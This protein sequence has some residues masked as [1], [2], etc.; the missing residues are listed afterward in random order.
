MFHKYFKL[1]IATP[2]FVWAGGEFYKG[3]IMNG[4]SIVFLASVFIFLYFKNEI[5]LV[6]FFKIRKQNMDGAKKWLAK[7]KSPEK[8]LI[9][10]QQAYYYFLHGLVASQTNIR[11]C[12]KFFRK[13]LAMGLKMKHNIA[14]AKLNLAGVALHKRRKR[15]ATL[16]ISEAKKLDKHGLLREQI[17]MMKQ[18]MKRI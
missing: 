15:E 2:I 17:T 11:S 12:E 8:S 10:S 13:A 3:N 4:I 5:L 14:I 7:I 9:K 6:V 18:Q 1:L 16:L